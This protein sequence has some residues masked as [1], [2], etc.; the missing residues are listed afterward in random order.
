VATVI[1]VIIAYLVLWAAFRVLGKREL[2]RMSPLELVLVLLI[3]QLFSRALTRQD[4][5][6][7]N[8]VVGATTLL[9]LVFLSSAMTYRS[10]RVSRIMVSRATVLVAD[11][12]F[13]ADALHEE[14]I[15]TADVYEAI[16]KAGLTTV[17]EVSWAILQSDGAIAIVP[18]RH[19]ESERG[20]TR[21]AARPTLGR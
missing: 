13:I 7:T 18:R 9:S 8:A 1:R 16:Q 17:Q 10:R 11:G 6:F 15:S 20:V 3:P 4:Y 2:T 19:V 12:D 5:S 21:G 14:R